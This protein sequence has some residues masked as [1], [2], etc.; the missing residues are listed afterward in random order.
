MLQKELKIINFAACFKRMKASLAYSSTFLLGSF[1]ALEPGHGKSF[2]AANLVDDKIG[3][4]HIFT[5]WASLLTSHFLM[6]TLIAIALQFLFTGFE[7]DTIYN[8]TEWVA[9]LLV[10]AFGIWLLIRY[11]KKSSGHTHDNCSCRHN[12]RPVENQKNGLKKAAT[13]GFISGLLPCP[14]AIAP[15]VLS[16]AS[17]EFGNIL[18]YILIYVLGMS[19]VL[20]A[21]V[22]VCFFARD[23]VLR[24]MNSFNSRIN[25]YLLSALLI[26]SVGVFYLGLNLV[27]HLQ[28]G[29]H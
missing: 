25:T 16:G 12:H 4:K 17:G 27:S 26:I 3:F 20:M 8:I 28:H 24:W 11:R 9:P 5:M 14:T 13:V 29:P 2:L 19:M 21:F 6:L 7:N 22:S 1:H 18:L 23:I 10:I 15:I